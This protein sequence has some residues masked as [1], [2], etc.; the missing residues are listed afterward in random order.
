MTDSMRDQVRA[1]YTALR[2]ARTSHLLAA[3]MPVLASP[4]EDEA[5]AAITSLKRAY[6]ALDDAFQGFIAAREIAQA[7]KV[8]AVMDEIAAASIAINRAVIAY[9]DGAADLTAAKKRVSDARADLEKQAKRVKTGGGT[10]KDVS[11]ALDGLTQIV[12]F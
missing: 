6:D 9:L 1:L 4:N 5:A 2:E 8:K 11:A 7:R 12:D 10:L 3:D